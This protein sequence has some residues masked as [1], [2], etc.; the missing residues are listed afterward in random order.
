MNITNWAKNSFEE[1]LFRL[2][3]AVLSTVQISNEHSKFKIFL[4]FIIDFEVLQSNFLWEQ[5]GKKKVNRGQLNAKWTRERCLE[6][7]VLHLQFDSFP[8]VNKWK[9]DYWSSPDF[10]LLGAEN[11]EFPTFSDLK[12][13][14]RVF[15]GL[16]ELGTLTNF[17][18]FW[19]SR[20]F[21][22]KLF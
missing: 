15:F 7:F 1:H 19:Y 5:E 6:F 16:V 13:F 20:T 10:Y 12:I 9:L 18:S 2:W 8:K 21:L 17:E 14:F 22:K 11:K 3:K 4:N